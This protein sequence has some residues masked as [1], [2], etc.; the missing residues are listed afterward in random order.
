MLIELNRGLASNTVLDLII[1][2]L[3]DHIIKTLNRNQKKNLE[4][5]GEK[6]KKIEVEDRNFE[7]NTHQNF[8]S[9][10]NN[11]STTFDRK[12]S[13]RDENSKSNQSRSF[14]SRNRQPQ[15]RKLFTVCVGQGM[16]N[17]YHSESQCW[18]NEETIQKESNKIE[19][20]SQ[21]ASSEEI[22]KN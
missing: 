1:V 22:P 12:F 10:K 5:L 15:M 18:Y 14:N 21:T 13:K 6:F 20:E 7:N 16:M 11:S 3:P 4:D 2:G 17:R 19:Y 8:K 9:N